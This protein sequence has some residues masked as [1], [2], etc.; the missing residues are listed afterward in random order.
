MIR[1]PILVFLCSLMLSRRIASLSLSCGT[2][3][4]RQFLMHTSASTTLLIS[5]GSA[6]SGV[7]LP[8]DDEILS[9][10]TGVKYRDD[11]IGQGDALSRGDVVVLHLQGIRRDGSIFLNTRD[12]GRP[13]LH[14]VGSAQAFDF[15]GNK[16]SQRAVVTMGVEDALRGMKLGGVRRI[17]VPSALAYGHAGVS[18]Y[19]AMKMGLIL[20]IPRDEFLRY[21]LELLRCVDLPTANNG[22][23]REVCCTEPNY[24]CQTESTD[25][26]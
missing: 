21:E 8:A 15:S 6:A 7:Q 23:S 26:D 11:R 3:H 1:P 20:P 16:S 13:I 24:P 17:V 9:T 4:R 22:L 5:Y 25:G 12:Q 14:K 10:I 2:G 19:D 18:R